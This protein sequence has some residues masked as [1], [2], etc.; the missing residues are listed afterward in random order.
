MFAQTEGQMASVERIM[1]YTLDIDSEEPAFLALDELED[2]ATAAPSS[3]AASSA[4]AGGAAD[5]TALS[6]QASS[7]E[8]LPEDWPRRGAV[9]FRGVTMGY[10]DGPDVLRDLSLELEAHEKVGVVGRTGSGKSSLMAALFRFVELRGGTITIDG[11][12]IAAVRLSRLRGSL[13]IIPQDPVMFSSTIR[14]NL[15]PFERHSDA[16]LW[17][18]LDQA[19]LGAAVRALPLRLTEVVSEGGENFSVGQRQLMCIARAILRSPAVLVLDEATA[20]I[21]NETD[22]LIQA[23]IRREF[24]AAT[25]LTVAHRLHTIMDS[26]RVLVLDNGAVAEFDTPQALLADEGGVFR[27]MVDAAKTPSSGNLAALAD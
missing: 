16:E 17:A 19:T 14:F 21:D 10:R 8:P 6:S 13:G 9:A 23:M 5:A 1:E 26:D 22:A 3:S 18:A 4:A 27:A 24:K 2:K 12:D 15:D 11:V 20:S 7:M 25:V